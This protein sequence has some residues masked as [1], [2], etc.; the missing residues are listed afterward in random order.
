ML[1]AFQDSEIHRHPED[2]LRLLLLD[3]K[4]DFGFPV[5]GR[6]DL[7]LDLLRNR[8]VPALVDF[9]RVRPGALEGVDVVERRLTVRDFDVRGLREL[10]Q[11]SRGHFGFPDV[12]IGHG[13]G[14]VDL[15]LPSG[16][17]GFARLKTMLRRRNYSPLSGSLH[18]KLRRF[19]LRLPPAHGS[20]P[21]WPSRPRVGNT[22]RGDR[23][24]RASGGARRR[25]HIF[26]ISRWRSIGGSA[27]GRR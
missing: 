12:P 5:D 1:D 2:I 25:Q 8:T 14:L 27:S 4:A 24:R 22:S 13:G 19:R 6:I 9:L 3:D 26:R 18:L 7:G 16:V 20:A 23:G 15:R 17:A 21:S 10:D 11:L